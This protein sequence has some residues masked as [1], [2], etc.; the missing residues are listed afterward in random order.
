M[1]LIILIWGS[2]KKRKIHASFYFFYINRLFIYVLTGILWLYLY[3]GEL[4][5]QILQYIM[6]PKEYQLILWFL[7]LWLFAVKVPI[8]P[9]HSWLPE[10]HV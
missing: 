3:I 6:L 7:F 5:I 10:A 1:F 2:R 8:Y 4:N 9:V